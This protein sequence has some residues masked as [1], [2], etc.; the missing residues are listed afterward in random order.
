M[1]IPSVELEKTGPS[2]K[3]KT[4]RWFS[5]RLRFLILVIGSGLVILGMG[6]L[7]I[8]NIA[9]TVVLNEVKQHTVE[10]VRNVGQQ[11]DDRLVRLSESAN[12]A[13]A[14]ATTASDLDQLRTTLAHMAQRELD[15]I[16]IYV[17]FD[18]QVISDTD[19]AAVWETRDTLKSN[20]A[21]K[22]TKAYYPNLLGSTAYDPNK[23]AY[24]Y[25]KDDP[26]F[27]TA[28]N[29]DPNK[30]VWTDSFIDVG[31]PARQFVVAAVTPIYDANKRFIGIAGVDLTFGQFGTYIASIKPTPNSYAMLIDRTG[32]VLTHPGDKFKQGDLGKSLVQ[33]SQDY[34]SPALKN[35]ADQM[36][37]GQTGVEEMID[38]LNGDQT[39]FAAYYPIEA[40][41]WSTAVFIPREDVIG[42]VNQMASSILLLTFI[43]LLAFGLIGLLLSETVVRPLIRLTKTAT[44]IST[45][46]LKQIAVVE[47]NDEIGTLASTLNTMTSR[48]SDLIDSLETRVEMRTAQIQASADI[49]QSATSILDPQQ[50][51]HEVVQLITDRF[52]YYYAAAFLVDETR[53]WAVLIEATGESG[54]KLKERGHRLEIGGRSMVSASITERQP[55]IALDVGVEAV[56]FA[57]PLL[58][59]TRSEISLPLIV[60]DQVLGALNV[61]STQPSAFDE[62]STIVLQ[63]MANQVAV[64]LNNATQYRRE[65]A[66]LDQIASLL[67][68]SLELTGQADQATLLDRIIHLT[69]RILKADEAGLWLPGPEGLELKAVLSATG[70]AATEQYLPDSDR[71]A[72]QVYTSGQPLL[73]D[74]FPTWAELSEQAATNSFH[75]ALGMPLLWQSQI[76]G[77]LVITH[78]DPTLRFSSDDENAANLLAAQAAAA[79]ANLKLLEQQLAT[80]REL[81]TVN[82]RLTGEA[83]QTQLRGQA[84]TH[85][86]QRAG[87]NLIEPPLALHF[88]IALRGQAI[89][90]VTIEDDQQQ[91][92]LTDDEHAIVQ[93]VIQQMTLALENQRLTDV[94]QQ[95]SQR[96]RAIAEAADKIHRPTDLDAILKVAAEEISRIVGTGDVRIRM[97]VDAPAGDGNG[98][99]LNDGRQA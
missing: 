29:A 33:L 68:A 32:Q 75:A 84:I 1:S 99:V 30:V 22:P 23:A 55:K 50:L 21:D 40:T 67:E 70:T 52:S 19:Y 18:R 98:H 85:V 41:G 87:A 96:D 74:D 71:I 53:Q 16:S 14:A 56:R 27:S 94:A 76:T 15:F 73:L 6:S 4:R 43:A 97:G 72:R 77:V 58:P 93:G 12:A 2:Q 36:I 7:A 38:P 60:G 24:D 46:D 17:F 82:R 10:I 13:A 45:G 44:A 80:L 28:K 39:V 83:W 62:S 26:R 37:A 31:G 92:R 79:L 34:N 20:Q 57:N 42:G 69:T 51:L 63:S 48:L 89:G 54:Q 65:R 8:F 61:Q 81:N 95:A 88:P 5:F 78:S 49:G 9:Q 91:R 3:P 90:A 86:T 47:R 35:M 66:R 11:L 64:A 25:F 59:D